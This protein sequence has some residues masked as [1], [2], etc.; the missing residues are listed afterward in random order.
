MLEKKK[1]MKGDRVA[2]IHFPRFS[3]GIDIPRPYFQ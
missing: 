1:I 3:D 2:V